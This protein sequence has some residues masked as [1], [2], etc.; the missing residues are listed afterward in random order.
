MATPDAFAPRPRA[1]AGAAA[2]PPEPAASSGPTSSIALPAAAFIVVL[3]GRAAVWA[4]AGAVRAVARA[5]PARVPG[6]AGDEHF[7]DPVAASALR[8]RTGVGYH[9][10]FVS[11][12]ARWPRLVYSH[13]VSNVNSCTRSVCTPVRCSVACIKSIHTTSTTT[14]LLT[15]LIIC[16]LVSVLPTCMARW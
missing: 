10:A 6:A 14:M 11:T 1:S 7:S 4:V 9:R 8:A 3:V 2:S 15:A 5:R 12:C 13:R 16:M